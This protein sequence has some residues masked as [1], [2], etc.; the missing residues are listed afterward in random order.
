MINSMTLPEL[1]RTVSMQEASKKDYL[2]DTSALNVQTN[3]HGDSNLRVPC[4]KTTTEYALTETARM[5]IAERLE[6]PFRYMEHIRSEHAA[7]YDQTVNTLF[8]F[9]NEPRLIRTMG[10]SCRAILSPK[11]RILDNYAFLGAFLP[12]LAELPEA[13]VNEAYLSDT[14]IHVSVIL[15]RTQLDVK[16]GDSVLFGVLL[17]NSEVGL[18]SLSVYHFLHRLVCSNGLVVQELESNPMRKIHLGRRMLDL[19]AI[20][21]EREVW[22]AYADHVRSTADREKF[23]Q[24]IQR[25]RL[26][27]DQMVTANPVDAVEEVAKKHQLSKAES[28]EVLNRFLAGRDLST[29][30]LVNAVTEAAKLASTSQRKVELQAVGGKLLP[31]AA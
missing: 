14:H 3:D 17:G 30:G 21:N 18:G 12:L 6:V 26:A 22:L 13:E 11:Y 8:K 16:P 24:L 28:E 1:V 5:Q 31:T 27:A 23:P 4:G 9:H 2:V 10:Q 25:L 19:S 7:L 15:R 29:W 20:P